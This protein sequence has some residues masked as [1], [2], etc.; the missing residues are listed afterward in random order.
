MMLL[1]NRGERFV[2]QVHRAAIAPGIV[3]FGET[4]PKPINLPVQKT[5]S[6]KA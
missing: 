6:S 3:V 2:D 1:G 4:Q 5:T